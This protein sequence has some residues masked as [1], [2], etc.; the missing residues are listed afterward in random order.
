M[1]TILGHKIFMHD[2]T[3]APFTQRIV[4]ARRRC[5]GLKYARPMF[6]ATGTNNERYLVIGHYTFV[7]G[8][9]YAQHK[10]GGLVPGLH[11]AQSSIV[12]TTYAR[13]RCSGH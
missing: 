9:L 13:R 12:A 5:S 7:V 8:I 1:H 6:T 11:Y 3:F 4:Y 2:K 10:I